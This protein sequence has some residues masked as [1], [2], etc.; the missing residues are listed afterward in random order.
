MYT[1]LPDRSGR[2]RGIRVRG[3]DELG[4]DRNQRVLP[5]TYSS[6][7]KRKGPTVPPVSNQKLG[8]R[9]QSAASSEL[10]PSFTRRFFPTGTRDGGRREPC[11]P[12]PCSLGERNVCRDLAAVGIPRHVLESPVRG[13]NEGALGCN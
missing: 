4:T 7:C 3:G 2:N 13:S 1:S 5:P 11:E 6:R 12:Q 9:D 10:F 8:R